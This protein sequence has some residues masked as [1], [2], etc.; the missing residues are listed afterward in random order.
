VEVHGLAWNE[1]YR[2]TANVNLAED[3]TQRVFTIPE[4]LYSS[5]ERIFFIDLK[6]TDSANRVVSRNFYWVPGT[7]T[8]FDWGRTDYTHTPAARYEDLSALTKLPTAHVN[9]TAEIE[10]T[11]RGPE[12]CVHLSNESATLA[13]QV[14]AAARTE[15]GDLIAPVFWSDNWIELPPGESTTLT[16]LLPA[17]STAS[18]VI[19]ID[20]WNIEALALTP[21]SATAAAKGD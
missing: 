1:L 5:A 4:K 6:L 7:L 2:A 3:S 14:N 21:K 11:P 18:P 13:F 8:T 16:A 20:G 10:Q 19:H 9:A 12:I 17:D 15:S